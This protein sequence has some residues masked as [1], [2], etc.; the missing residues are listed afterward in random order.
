MANPVTSAPKLARSRVSECD[1]SIRA[2]VSSWRRS[3]VSSVANSRSSSASVGGEVSDLLTTSAPVPG[4]CHA[5]ARYLTHTHVTTFL[6]A[7]VKHRIEVRP[8]RWSG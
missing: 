4:K 6:D 3:V 8:G 5:V 7:E 1:T 2:N